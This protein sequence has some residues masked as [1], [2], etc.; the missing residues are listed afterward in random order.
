[1]FEKN[2]LSK[3]FMRI[4]GKTTIFR[5]LL[6][7]TVTQNLLGT[8][9]YFGKILV[10]KKIMDKSG[11]FGIK[12]LRRE[13]FVS[14]CRKNFMGN[15][16]VFQEISVMEKNLDKRGRGILF[17]R[18]K[19]FVS[20][21]QKYSWGTLRF[22]RKIGYRKN[23][24]IIGGYQYFPLNFLVSQCRKTSWGSPSAFQKVLCVEKNH[25]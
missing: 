19:F 6:G 4:T 24:C 13:F 11:G 9:L 10:W 16:F 25:A 7:L 23:L 15:A 3:R 22:F 17:F 18:R 21:C 14:Q 12:F 8:L 5:Q 1:M 2:W 20:Q